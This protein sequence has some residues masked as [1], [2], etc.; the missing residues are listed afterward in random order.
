M[1]KEF[2]GVW[3]PKAIYTAKLNLSEKFI[4]SD[5]YNLCSSKK[6]YFKSNETLSKELGISETSV[7]RSIKSLA[8]S[9][10]VSTRYDG[11]C[12]RI[13][14]TTSLGKL[15]KQTC[16][17]DKGTRQIDKG[18]RQIDKAAMSKRQG[19]IQESIQESIH[20]SKRG[21]ITYPFIEK[22]FLEAWSIWIDERKQ[23]QLKRYTPRGE[24]G[25]LH[26]LQKESDNNVEVAIE[27]INYAICRGWQGIYPIKN[28]VQRIKTIDAKSAL[29][30]ASKA[31]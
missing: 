7:S 24:Q 20:L 9:G 25:A 12:R 1:K 30:W 10:Y 16:Q 6:E 15:T 17:I 22:E 29:A 19:S 21:D 23:K 27:M 13:K 11:R 8:F 3:I 31:R 28:N 26:T 2:T 14:L 4:L 18:T 5:I